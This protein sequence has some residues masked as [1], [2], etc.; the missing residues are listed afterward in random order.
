MNAFRLI[1]ANFNRCR[2]GLRIIEEFSRFICDNAEHSSLLKKFRHDLQKIERAY[3]HKVLPY[4]DTLGDVGTSISTQSETKR[5]DIQ[6]V[7]VASFKRLQE[8]LRVLEE[9]CKID[10]KTNAQGLEKL[11]YR[12][13]QLEKQIL[14]PFSK[15][16]RLA[17]AQLYA[18]ITKDLCVHSPEKTAELCVKGGVDII[19]LR[20]KEM[21][22]KQF[23]KSAQ[24]VQKVLAGTGVIL[25]INDNIPIAQAIDA[26]GVHLGQDD[27][28]QQTAQ[29]LL[30]EHKIIGRSTHSLAQARK[31]EKDGADYIGVG[32]VWET[33][34]KKH[35]CA[36]GLDLVSLVAQHIE[37]PFYPIGSIKKENAEEV[38]NAGARR[39]AVCTGITNTRQV[40]ACCRAFKKL[41]SV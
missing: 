11:R 39:L 28:P 15:R 33:N 37:I 32:P 6:S 41:L 4:R 17:K 14:A 19:Q 10:N 31:A 12:S 20:E 7:V 23:L 29:K 1:D 30:G 16:E 18:L 38:L 3:D 36:V 22:D 8:A 25:L 34:T 26:D 35:R 24:R 5:S 40:S 2:E 27:L 9:Y 13:Y 21:P